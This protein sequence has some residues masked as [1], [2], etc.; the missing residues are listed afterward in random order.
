MK[1]F[2]NNLKLQPK[3]VLSH[4][5]VILFSIFTVTIL[6]NGQLRKIIIDNTIN[7]ERIL[8]I[9]ATN[10]IESILSRIISV[11]DILINN[12]FMGNITSSISGD[13]VRDSSYES[14]EDFYSSIRSLIDGELITGIRIFT[15]NEYSSLSGRSKE[16]EAIFA[17]ISAAYGTYWYG[18]FSSE[19]RSSLLCPSLYLSPYELEKQGEL[20]Y[21]TRICYDTFP[22]L[23]AAYCVI[24]FSKDSLDESLKKGTTLSDSSSYIINGRDALVSTSDASLSGGYLVSS[25]ELQE[26]FGEGN[27]LHLV[28]SSNG[29]IYSGYFTI[30]NSDWYMISIIPGSS[31]L[32]QVHLLITQYIG[33]YLLFMIIALMIALVLSHSIVKRISILNNQMRSARH[34]IPKRLVTE[35]YHDEIGEL[36]AS[37]NFMTDELN[38]TI[39]KRDE[40]AREL[41]MSEF[42]ALQAQIN[43]H[44]LYNSLDM[45]QWLS[46]SGR[47]EEVTRAVLSL[48]KFYKLTLS[49]RDNITTIEQELTHASLY[50][51]IQNMRYDN[52]IDFIEDVQDELMHCSILKLTLQPI[53]ENS[54]LHGILEKDSPSGMIIITGWRTNKDILLT[55][56]DD[57]VGIPEEKMGSL[58]SESGPS[59]SYSGH[60]SNIGIYNTH[61]R[62]EMLYGKG[63]GLT[64]RSKPGE[65]T[66]VEI[67]IPFKMQD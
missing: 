44:F 25:Q 56:T 26:R 46:D 47:K 52:Q 5:I 7:S 9:Q 6:F 19:N 61:R 38:Q 2:F 62:L 8:S 28:N 29:D 57:G 22:G 63:Y 16:G 23:T 20:A 21:I 65:G 59:K 64:Y 50:I 18:I 42:R 33:F 49:R 58:L 45:I 17:P 12:A 55:V 43:P 41:Q 40:M 53:I 34:G 13:A 37:Y 54:I 51:N 4:M 1:R 24:Y 10:N 3:L 27:D 32:N 30:E 66:S 15:D 60:S 48:A 67:K 36:I 39:E 14:R 35:E 31:L 11:S